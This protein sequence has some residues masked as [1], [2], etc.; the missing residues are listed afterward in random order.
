MTQLS[1]TPEQ[2]LELDFL[3]LKILQIDDINLLRAEYIHLAQTNMEMRNT[4]IHLIGKHWGISKSE[5]DN[6][7]VNFAIRVPM[8]ENS[9]DNLNKSRN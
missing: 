9:N 3:K 4:C 5:P 2:Q 1:I 7:S 8:P 6:L